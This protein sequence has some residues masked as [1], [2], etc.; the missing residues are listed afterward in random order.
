M[1][2][3]FNSMDPALERAMSE[4]RD[5][6]VDPVVI[7]A[8]AAR[9]WQKLAGSAAPLIRGCADFQSLI[10]DYRAGVLPEAR[11]MLLKDHLH[12]C[13]ACR[14]VYEGKVVTMPGARTPSRVSHNFRWAAAA[15]VV[16]TAGLS[17]WIAIDQFGGRTGRAYVKTI[18]GTLYEVSASGIRPLLLNQDLPDG[19]EIRTAKDS[20]ATLQLRDGSVVEL[21][22]RSDFSTSQTARDLTV[23]LDR[24]S[25]IVQAA[26]RS[27]GHL[28]VATADCR[29]AVTG[30]VFSVSAGAKGSRVSVIQGE[31]RFSQDN[32]EKLLHPGDQAVT[33]ASL[34][35][36]S[37]RD[38]I[39]WSRNPELLKQ[40]EALRS[41]LQQ[42]H[43]PGPRYSSK[44]LDRLPASTVF[45]IAIPNLASY[46][47][48][49][50]SAVGKNL[51]QSPALRAWWAG[52]NAG[53]EPLLEKLR[54]GSEYLGDEIVIAGFSMPR[55]E[56]PAMVLFAEV[57]REGFPEFLKREKLPVVMEQRNGLAAFG[58]DRE[59][60][61]A[62]APALDSASNGFAGTPFHARI[63]AAYRDGAGLLACADLSH[64]SGQ[65]AAPS[66]AGMRFLVAEQK[67]VNQQMEARATLTFDGPRTGIA[68]WLAEPA[69]MGSLDY[70]SPD[71]TLVAAFVV[72]N[73]SAI[74]DEV[75]AVA[76]RNGSASPAGFDPRQDLAPGL[77]G[78]FAL[79]LD[80]P[81]F[82]VP[83]WKLVTEVYDPARVESG[84]EKL[85][86]AYGWRTAQETVDGR[87]YYTLAAQNPNPLTE[88][89]Y[90][91]ADGYLIGGPT[92]DVVAKAL[93]VKRAGVSITRSSRFVE[94]APRDHYANFSALVYNNL[95]TTL[96]PIVGLLGA[97]A[98]Q[99]RPG[100]PNPLN[101][102]ANVKP[103]MIAAYGEPDRI[104]VAS[105]GDVMGM[106]LTNFLSGNVLGMAGNVL[107]F[108]QFHGTRAR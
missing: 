72:R 94:M 97:F 76:G 8:A 16:A 65:Q 29:V 33:G 24:G 64:L 45:Y 89:H 99:Q 62:F 40:L 84:L 85:A 79:S 48:D 54:A 90:T 46:L 13:V 107:P 10:P 63:A 108:G 86:R 50:Q 23:H 83:S 87:T 25:I 36:V 19:V 52:R 71:A 43:L 35:K 67:E 91:F 2:L 66:M 30:T 59:T 77:G 5:E 92:R 31:V 7:E 78:E 27:S 58:P 28:F 32:Q 106:S 61:E 51:E 70:V 82:P 55:H 14:R 98:P 102:L 39:S 88:A 26:R 73:P 60:V 96:A 41:S 57:K 37:I 100:Q 22:E 75:S 101:G 21:R 95:G 3:E 104:T 93:Q 81:A 44:L 38:D 68:A 74:V 17:I 42:V 9:V 12:E 47:G 80:G 11:A 49:V 34:E 69:P 15:V 53:V 103:W 20:H 4:I 1:S 56:M 105:N 18:D 6:S